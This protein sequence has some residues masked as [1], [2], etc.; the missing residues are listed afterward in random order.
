MLRSRV[1]SGERT[2][3]PGV[4]YLREPITAVI[5]GGGQS[6]EKGLRAA[7]LATRKSGARPARRRGTPGDARPDQCSVPRKGLALMVRVQGWMPT[8]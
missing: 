8:F 3:A 4:R 6:R 2:V 5:G 7:K 1:D